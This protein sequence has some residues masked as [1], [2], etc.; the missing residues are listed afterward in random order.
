MKD[1]MK[2]RIGSCIL[3][4]LLLTACVLLFI[5]GSS[6]EHPEEKVETISGI[7]VSYKVHKYIDYAI[8]DNDEMYA[9]IYLNVDNTIYELK[10]KKILCEIYNDKIFGTYELEELQLILDNSINKYIVIQYRQNDGFYY[11][12]HDVISVC[13]CEDWEMM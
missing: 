2:D 1:R 7:L 6:A 12:Y 13:S 3:I 5:A 4:I 8:L 10:G 9:T 11:N